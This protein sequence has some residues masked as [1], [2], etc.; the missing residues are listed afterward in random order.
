MAGNP[1]PTQSEIVGYLMRAEDC[2]HTSNAEGDQVP[3]LVL[4]VQTGYLPPT[5]EGGDPVDAY[6]IIACP[7]GLV[8]GLGIPVLIRVQTTVIGTDPGNIVSLTVLPV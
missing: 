3:A 5:E 4:Q 8:P 6:D 7:N 1:A 2:V